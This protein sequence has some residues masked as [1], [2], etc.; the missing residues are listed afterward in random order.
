MINT[1][2]FTEQSVY[3][4]SEHTNG[5][6]RW[7]KFKDGKRTIL[8]DLVWASEDLYK[9]LCE[10]F[11]YG[12]I[13]VEELFAVCREHQGSTCERFFYFELGS[14]EEDVKS[15]G[16]IDSSSSDNERIRQEIDNRKFEI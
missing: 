6:I 7:A 16:H 10:D 2:Y 11:E 9:T 15:S 4:R 14:G 1:G 3:V 8:S 13:N 5:N 12:K